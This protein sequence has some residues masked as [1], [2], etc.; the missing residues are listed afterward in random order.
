MARQ[1]LDGIRVIDFG[2]G[3]AVPELGRILGE[4]GA[5]V[6]EVESRHYVDFMRRI[7]PPGK[8][9][10][11]DVDFNPGFNEANRNKRSL[12]VNMH[13]SRGQ[14]LMRELI[15]TADIVI[16]NN[17]REVVEKWGVDY[18]RAAEVKPDIIYVQST[19]FGGGGPYENYRSFGG[20]VASSGF[21][22][23]ASYPDSERPVG[24]SINHPD[25]IAGKLLMVPVI[26]AL[27]YRRRTGKG[28]F[29]DVSQLETASALLG[30]VFL[31]LAVN[32]RMAVPVGNRNPYA[33]PH[34]AYRCRGTVT[35]GDP[36]L[37]ST[38]P[39]AEDRWVA[40]SA[41]TEREWVGLCRA[42]G[43]PEWTADPRFDTLVGRKR[44]ED[45]L[46]RLIEAWTSQRDAFEVQDL[47]QKH[48]VPAGVVETAED[49]IFGDPQMRHRGFILDQEHLVAG[50]GYWPGQPVRLSAAPALASNPAEP[51]GYSTDR[52]VGELLG[53]DTA[54]I[55]DLRAEGV[56]GY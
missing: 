13:D 53:M 51:L 12:A 6:I 30:E 54:L 23:L 43:D 24:L 27:D 56:I 40:I 45:E 52:I 1:V 20:A 26:A 42:M 34:G 8:N 33:A 35:F 32:D 7:N 19:G 10:A 48:G 4:F 37:P 29:I 3:A 2:Q 14:E 22:F 49:H 39:P 44:N 36:E 11:E 50:K 15:K 18:A 21:H 17:Q 28:Q 31:D 9:P 46:D 47:L 25:H 41:F 16:D 5:D 55:A 38:P